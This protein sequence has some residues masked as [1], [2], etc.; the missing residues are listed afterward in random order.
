MHLLLGGLLLG[1]ALG[2]NDASNMFGTAVAS[3]LITFRRA[4][5]LF[6]LAVIAGAV[7]QGAAGF[8]LMSDMSAQDNL[9]LVI[10]PLAAALTIVIM[11]TLK[12]PISAV[13]AMIGAVAGIGLVTG[14]IN[15]TGL[16]KVAI[17][18]V[19][20][21]LGAL[22]VCIILQQLLGRFFAHVPMSI[23]TREK[24]LS[25]GLLVVGTYGSYALGADCVAIA[26]G[27][28]SGKIAYLSDTALALI[29]GLA[30]ALGGLTY[31]KRMIYVVGKDLMVM[32]AFTALVA[33]LSMSVTM[34]VFALI[35]VPVS[36]RQA[37]I[38]SIV[39]LSF[40]R[41]FQTI[42][43]DILRNICVGWLL[44]PAI[45]LVLAAAGYAIACRL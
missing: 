29:G 35:G 37:I 27:I 11:I 44:T 23:L 21:P 9:S 34:H 7:A 5:L 17:C 14:T 31:G 19:V 15:G 4:L 25:L 12:L 10:T 1:W 18:W 24:V 26:T 16:G 45:A 38:G 33:V 6:G 32:D 28:F 3:R 20:T 22:V 8:R 42:R 2:A 41:G 39:G 40:M 43:V 30:I 13:Q 36:A